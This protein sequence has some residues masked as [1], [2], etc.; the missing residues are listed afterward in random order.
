M[1]LARALDMRYVGQGFELT[2]PVDGLEGSTASLRGAYN[3][4]HQALYGRQMLDAPVEVVTF[5]SAAVGSSAGAPP[6]PLAAPATGKPEP[7]D[8][9]ELLD[10][11]SAVPL[12]YYGHRSLP[13]GSRLAGPAVIEQ[14]TSTTYVPPAGNSCATSTRR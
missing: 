4:W 6:L 10:G 12:P 1:T 3:D 8:V 11:G 7:V 14:D 5:R 9:G 2:V 13:V